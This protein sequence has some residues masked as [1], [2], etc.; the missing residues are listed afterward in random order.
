[1]IVNP[2]KIIQWN[3]D[4]FYSHHEDF[5]LLLNEYEPYI[6]CLQ[7]TK[8]KFNHKPKLNNYKSYYRNVDSTTVAKGGVITYIKDNF[9][10]EEIL[11]NTNLQIVAVKVFYPIEFI[12]CNIYLQGNEQIPTNEISN[13]LSQFNSPFML[14]GDFNAHNM[15]WGSNHIDNRGA[16]IEK[17]IEDH[18]LNLLNSGV[19]T[20]FSFGYK[21]TSAIDLTLVSPI[22]DIYF[23]WNID[24]DLHS[25]D[26]YPIIIT[27]SNDQMKKD[28]KRKWIIKKA[29]WEMYKEELEIKNINFTNV[30]EHE[31]YIRN[32]IIDAATKS[33]PRSG[34]KPLKKVVPWWNNEINELIK[35]RKIN[36]RKYQ[37]TLNIRYY[38]EF[39]IAKYQSRKLVRELKKETWKQ[40]VQTINI[41]TSSSKVYSKI[42]QIAGKYKNNNITTLLANGDLIT[43]T[44]VICQ[45][46]AESFAKSSSTCNYTN[47]FQQHK[48]IQEQN[49]LIIPEDN[50][51]E[52]YND[53]FSISELENAL[54]SC[55]GSSPGPD[56]IHYEMIKRM[57]QI[58]KKQLLNL[59][60]KMYFERDF[61]EN[62]RNALLIP[63]LKNGKDPKSTKNYRPIALTN[64]LCKVFERMINKRIIWWME[65]KDKFNIYQ[66]GF[67]KHR[68]TAD[69]ICFL[70]SQVMEAFSNQ[71][72]LISIFFDLEKAYDATWRHLVIKETI[73][74]GLKGNIVHFI[75]NF[76]FERK[77]QVS[78]GSQLSDEK[79][80]ENG[81][82]QGSVLSVT[83]FIIAINK[84]FTNIQYPVKTVMY[85]DD[86]VIF[87][88]SK[89]ITE[90]K[91]TLQNTLN[92]LTEWCKNSGFKFST[93]KT[94]ALVFTRK[95]KPFQKPDLFL[96]GSKI[97]YVNEYKF[98]GVTFDSKLKWTHHIKEVKA[99][100][101]RN[102]NMI[103]MLAHSKYGS[104]RK[105]LLKIHT[106]MVLP[107]LDYGN[108]VYSTANKNLINTINAVHNA[109]IRLATGAFRT[110][111]I[112]SVMA[113]AEQTPLQIRREKQL[114]FYATK[115]LSSDKHVLY[116]LFQNQQKYTKLR[117]KNH[118]YQPFYV[119]AK[120]TLKSYNIN[121]NI[122]FEKQKFHKFPPWKNKNMK[123]DLSLSKFNKAE[124]SPI[125]FHTHV[126]KKIKQHQHDNI[127]YTDG[128]VIGKATGC[129]LYTEEYEQQFHLPDNTSIFSAEMFAI[130][131]AVESSKSRTNVVFS[132]S[133]SSLQALKQIYSNNPLVQQI[134]DIIF[135]TQQSY[136]FIWIPSHI[137]INGN[138]KADLLAK[139]SINQPTHNMYQYIAKDLKRTIKHETQEKW[140]KY[141]EAIPEDMNK[142]RKIMA[143][144]PKWSNLHQLTRIETVKLTRLRIGHTMATHKFVFERTTPP[145]CTCK[146]SL[147]VDHI[148]NNCPIYHIRRTKYGITNS[149]ILTEDTESSI[150]KIMN[151]LKETKL[152]EKI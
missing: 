46:L 54:I 34:R 74:S 99:K 110:S 10:S 59:Y 5:K 90:I 103:K 16:K 113:D 11:L 80:I 51:T 109:G 111:P 92:K 58:N 69:N 93:E 141:W 91:Q 118:N 37:E 136:T 56:T 137:G 22:L 28:R 121:Q 38:R 62:W 83:L 150:N 73:A 71:Q 33:I 61:P 39:I 2:N 68:A 82:P 19:P 27:V 106:T 1:M 134:H 14:L 86:L 24:D 87:I 84:I 89:N 7:E 85:A 94:K 47:E 114:L 132:D 9:D 133:L 32:T 148:F 76:L 26:H 122:N 30:N 78:I 138:E 98:L 143:T 8:F 75:K 104:D 108:L 144:I 131:K 21:T 95:R 77:V 4:G 125:V 53:I 64:C 36:L 97:N 41:N 67:R 40:F 126:N 35:L 139:E 23:D 119:R 63:I 48:L 29:N 3:C 100:A 65:T 66:S 120:N 20:H 96:C 112:D 147:T 130:K 107:V 105:T 81:I 129:A 49:A 13:I 15:L 102:L 42:R 115:I 52:D 72:Y 18:Q 116:D 55:K 117:N 88:S 50:N 12:I 25:S 123:I 140:R 146:D 135:S 151:F 149:Q 79:L 60:N 124:T 6:I 101:T 152:Y 128:S 45:E 31:S 57:T 70:E 142:L 127:I 17:V 43:N 44:Q 145:I